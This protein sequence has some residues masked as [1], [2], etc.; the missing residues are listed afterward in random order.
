MGLFQ[1]PMVPLLKDFKF[2]NSLKVKT[3][4]EFFFI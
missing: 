2:G 4:R 1:F 3:F